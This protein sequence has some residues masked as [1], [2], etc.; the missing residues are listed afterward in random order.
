MLS[1]ACVIDRHKGRRD[2]A[3]MQHGGIFGM[4][5]IQPLHQKPDDLAFGNLDTDIVEQGRQSLRRDLPMGVKHQAEAS[6]IGAIASSD[7]CRQR[8]VD[9]SAIRCQPASRR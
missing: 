6:P 1:G 2:Q 7:S 3:G 9:R 4:K 8:R 5:A